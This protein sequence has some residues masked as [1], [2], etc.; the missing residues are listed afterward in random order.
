[1]SINREVVEY[2]M[3][4]EIKLHFMARQEKFKH[5]KIFSALLSPLPTS[6]VHC[7]SALCID[8]ASPLAGIPAQQ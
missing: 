8:Q 1:M 7:V 5:K 6:T 4:Y 3:V 2:I